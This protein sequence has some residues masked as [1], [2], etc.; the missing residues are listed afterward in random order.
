MNVER[1]L[2]EFAILGFLLDAIVR[3]TLRHLQKCLS[4]NTSGVSVLERNG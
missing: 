4:M 1:D 3:E 2:A